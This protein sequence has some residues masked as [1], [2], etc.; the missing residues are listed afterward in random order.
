MTSDP[1]STTNKEL[2]KITLEKVWEDGILTEEEAVLLQGLRTTL[3]ISQEIHD[4]LEKE[5]KENINQVTNETYRLVLEQAWNDGI[6]TEDESAMLQK[7]RR[8]LKISD[9][10]H[11]VIESQVK[12]HLPDMD[13]HGSAIQSDLSDDTPEYWI[14]KGEAIWRKSSHSDEAANKAMECFDKAIDLDP[15]NYLAW[16]NKGLILKKLNRK[17]DAIACYD[18][19]IEINPKFPNAWFNKGVLLGTIGK[20]DDAITCL[21]EVLKIKPDNALAKRD[22]EILLQIQQ[23]KKEK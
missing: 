20:I 16:S 14:A 3:N 8:G 9:E 15:L 10:V 18:K 2:Y 7:L 17:E 5:V 4:E 6:I 1:T 21:D 23:K 13:V 12:K 19:A 11:A 22:R